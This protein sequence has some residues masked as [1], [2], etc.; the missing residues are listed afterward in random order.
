MKTK[1]LFLI[2]ISIIFISCDPENDFYISGKISDKK[3]KTTIENADIEFICYTNSMEWNFEKN[4]TQ[5]NINGMYNDTIV[6]LR[7]FDS[8]KIKINKKGY[9]T[10]EIISERKEW[11]ITRGFM[12]TEFDID[13]GNIE[14]IKK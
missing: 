7:R 1:L 14:L 12:K 5:T 11:E 10:K 8:I 4:I 13:C 6:S 9:L 3:H 2:F